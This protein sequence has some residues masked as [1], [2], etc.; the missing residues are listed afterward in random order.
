[1]TTLTVTPRNDLGAVLL[2]V[3]GAPAGPVVIY[4]EDR[5]GP[6]QV[7]LLPNQEPIS[8]ALTV[9]D[10]EAALEGTVS[11]TVTDSAAGSAS[12][13]V[14]MDGYSPIITAAALP[15]HRA[16]VTAVTDYDSDQE[17]GG[18]VHWVV[19]RPDPLVVTAPLRSR[20]GSFGVYC[21]TYEEARNVVSIGEVGVVM[22]LRQADYAGMDMYFI[23]RRGRI[24]P[25]PEETPLRRWEVTFDYTEV[26]APTGS[27]NGAGGWNFDAAKALG[28]FN[29]V[30]ALFATFHDST[31]GP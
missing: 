31:V 2:E 20:E 29:D 6:G 9:Y 4:R 10:H 18:T 11:Y 17:F 13:S 7:R 12:A 1:M 22:Q 28:T 16:I 25:R 27:L 21:S 5:N 23:P 14:T 24:S 8:G 3:A 15:Q 26:K 30:K 19:D